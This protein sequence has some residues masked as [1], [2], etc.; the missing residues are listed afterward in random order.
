M[1]CPLSL[2]AVETASVIAYGKA[3]AEERYWLAVKISQIP[4]LQPAW[5]CVYPVDYLVCYIAPVLVVSKCTWL[6]NLLWGM[7]HCM[8]H[9]HRFSW[10]NSFKCLDLVLTL[11]A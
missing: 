2:A 10:R 11:L 7:L 9:H 3:A 8:G 5:V 1:R 4:C 6:A